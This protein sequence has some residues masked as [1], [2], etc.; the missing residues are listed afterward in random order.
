MRLKTELHRWL[1][2]LI[3]WTNGGH[4]RQAVKSIPDGEH[5]LPFDV[6]Y[7]AQFAS[8][9]RIVDYIHNDYRGLDDPRWHDF[10]AEDPEDYAFWAP[11]VCA[12]ACLKMALAAHTIASPTLW[13]LV[14]EGLDLN[15]YTVYGENGALIDEGW[16]VDA[17]IK[18]AARYG[19]R[20]T[21]YS[22]ASPL[23]VAAS[24]YAGKLVA[25]TVT[26][27]IGER[28]PQ[29]RRYGG[30]LIL[31]TGFRWQAGKP[32]AFRINNPSGR[33]KELQADAWIAARRFQQSY[34]YRFAT[35]ER[36]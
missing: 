10:G 32:T 18:L 34:A 29:S 17:Q 26:P 23:G 31:V 28:T 4:W 7:V 27:E 25:A 15:G 8:P 3:S 1:D 11:R 13:Q 5:L 21:G 6:P 30:H 20:L 24:I 9:E 36:C 14:Q 22:Y 19:L 12:L 2:P 16:Y 33:F 35:F